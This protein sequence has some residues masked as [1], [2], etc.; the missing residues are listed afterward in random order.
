MGTYDQIMPG[1]KLIVKRF[2]VRVNL[3]FLLIDPGTRG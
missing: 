3:G 1:G 2:K